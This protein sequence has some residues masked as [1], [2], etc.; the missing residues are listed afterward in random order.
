MRAAWLFALMGL[1]NTAAS[2]ASPM[3]GLWLTDDHKGVVRIGACG[4]HTCGWMVRVLDRGPNV[5]THDV[6]NPDPNLRGRTIVGMP[7]LTGF[8]SDGS[9][10]RAYDP[11]SGRS[12]RTSMS[13]NGDGSL[14]VTGCVVLFLCQS[15][16]WTRAR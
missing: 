5:P 3:D 12:Y 6:N 2:A 16:R 9:G 15:V 4:G 13:V 8:A 10:G 14:T 1:W 7:I 11:R